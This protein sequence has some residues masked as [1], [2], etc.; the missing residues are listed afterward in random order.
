MVNDR[1]SNSSSSSC[2]FFVVAIEAVIVQSDAGALNFAVHQCFLWATLNKRRPGTLFASVLRPNFQTQ[3]EADTGAHIRPGNSSNN[4]RFAESQASN[5][6]IELR[7][8][9]DWIRKTQLPSRDTNTTSHQQSEGTSPTNPIR[10]GV[11]NPP[12]LNTYPRRGFQF[13]ASLDK[14]HGWR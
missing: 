8:K 1:L 11:L 3:I 5:S 9:C 6:H 4:I 10:T 14:L 2:V 12:C 7:K 13:R